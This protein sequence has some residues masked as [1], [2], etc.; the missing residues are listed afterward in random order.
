[1][2]H[3]IDTNDWLRRDEIDEIWEHWR[4]VV[5][6]PKA[7]APP[8][9][10]VV[11][12]SDDWA[13]GLAE[14]WP[15][16]GG[17]DEQLAQPAPDWSVR[18]LE[19]CLS[20]VAAVAAHRQ[21]AALGA[22]PAAVRAPR[23]AVGGS[24]LVVPQR[25]IE[26]AASAPPVQASASARG[27]ADGPELRE[28]PERPPPA[29]ELWAG[30]HAQQQAAAQ[31]AAR[32]RQAAQPK[33]LR[34][35]EPEPQLGQPM[36][37]SNSKLAVDLRPEDNYWA[38]PA[39]HAASLLHLET[40][41]EAASVMSD[42]GDDLP[43]DDRAGVYSL[44]EQ[45]SHHRWV[46]EVAPGFTIEVS[47]QPADIS[48]DEDFE[49]EGDVG[50]AGP[51][52]V[53]RRG[54]VADVKTAPTRRG[55]MTGLDTP[56]QQYGSLDDP[57]NAAAGGYG[58][59]Y[60]AYAR[61]SAPVP[62]QHSATAAAAAPK[63]DDAPSAG[64][65]TANAPDAWIKANGSRAPPAP[66]SSRVNQ[67]FDP[68]AFL[69]EEDLAAPS[70]AS[71]EDDNDAIAQP[72]AA[73]IR[74]R[75]ME[76]YDV[77]GKELT[78]L[79]ETVRIHQTGD[80]TAARELA[81]SRIAQGRATPQERGLR[82]QM[83]SIQRS[84]LNHS[85]SQLF[86]AVLPQYR[87]IR[88][89]AVTSQL[90][91]F[92][93]GNVRDST[94]FE[95]SAICVLQ[96]GE[97]I[98]PTDLALEPSTGKQR[99]HIDIQID[100]EETTDGWVSVEGLDGEISLE[101]IPE[102]EME[103]AYT[104]MTTPQRGASVVPGQ[105][106]L[107][108]PVYRDFDQRLQQTFARYDA[109]G[110]GFL[111]REQLLALVVTELGYPDDERTQGVVV[112]LLERFG[113]INN[114]A[115]SE[116]VIDAADFRDLWYHLT[117]MQKPGQEASVSKGAMNDLLVAKF[118]LYDVNGDGTLNKDEL[119]KMIIAEFKLDRMAGD[120]GNGASE[121]AT[122]VL[123]ALMLEF[124]SLDSNS[125]G[126]IDYEE[127]PTVWNHLCV[128]SSCTDPCIVIDPGTKICCIVCH[129]V[130]MKKRH[131]VDGATSG[132]DATDTQQ[133]LRSWLQ[134][135]LNYRQ[136]MHKKHDSDVRSYRLPFN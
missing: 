116:Q 62:A 13:S 4:G 9:P 89:V 122:A 40:D 110:Q 76:R 68:V 131:G 91:L 14:Q 88:Q 99:V 20:K 74:Q 70:I 38:R 26:P 25:Q 135:Q 77:L 43:H 2:Q 92:A 108:S 39:Q 12:L 5:A 111:N 46:D 23:G 45:S 104:N 105:Q 42:F 79:D 106:Q 128:T 27:E 120:S 130:R 71:T 51:Q 53:R 60:A 133:E 132:G 87:C 66:P 3:Y 73:E 10:R 41:S 36:D 86:G 102:E 127:F 129:R 75:M 6:V 59:A 117:R 22:E 136:D 95:S 134:A 112:V 81:L 82:D 44:L 103:Q 50:G 24:E 57:L 33:I 78:D 17:E 55:A 115:H 114:A 47:S 32:R 101:R 11:D 54:A 65:A 56:A 125:D 19:T 18:A 15:G 113:T 84:G 37:P 72:T 49:D 100:D 29:E 123:D 83:R 64:Q 93:G 85:T 7:P 61:A 90:A 96:A 35:P 21:P 8:T 107:Q 119:Q 124:G 63:S 94:I 34:E 1:M 16:D 80:L 52:E 126:L 121:Y 69:S 97:I 48:E 58:A 109:N 118:S 28:A 67:S 98:Q 31:A 30:Q